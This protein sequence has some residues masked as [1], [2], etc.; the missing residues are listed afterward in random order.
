MP[1][2]QHNQHNQ[3]QEY[4]DPK[5]KGFFNYL[6]RFWNFMWNGES[7]WS[8]VTFM[9]VAFIV[10]RFI[11]F[12]T[13]S[14]VTGTNLPIVIVES[15]SMY[16]GENFD[17]WWATKG[18]WYTNRNITKEQFQTFKFTNGFTKGDIFFV[19]GAKKSDI[20]VG[21]II[22]FNS[23]SQGRPIIHRVISL[24]PIQTKGDHNDGQ[25]A[26]QMSQL[27]NPEGIDETNIKESQIIGK[28]VGFKL[29]FLGW[30]KLIFYEP[31][32]QSY[33]K[34]FCKI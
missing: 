21:D 17:N 7:I 28:V 1:E 13:L 5:D 22:I 15:C 12:P 6:K 31:F 2:N 32:R 16:H 26:P 8:W 23:G 18:N 29:P 27:S 33:E 4:R 30:I 34:G 11:F 9:I 20:K 10:I 14:F 25:F 19:V 3:P 24:D